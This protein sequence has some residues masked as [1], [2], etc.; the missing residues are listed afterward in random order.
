M[1]FALNGRQLSALQVALER[2][3]KR[4]RNVSAKLMMMSAGSTT[5][6]DRFAARILRKVGVASGFS[7]FALLDAIAP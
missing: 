4:A 5:M 3:S 7:R 2:A 6:R 1:E